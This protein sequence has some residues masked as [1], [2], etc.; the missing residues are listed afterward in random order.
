[1]AYSNLGDSEHDDDSNVAVNSSH[2]PFS[3]EDDRKEVFF[4][5]LGIIRLNL[6]IF[7]ILA[8]II[9][10]LVLTNRKL[11]SPTSM[12]LLSLVVYDAVYLLLVIPLSA[13]GVYVNFHASRDTM[14][15]MWTITRVTYPLR[16]MAQMGS[17][18]TT[19]TITIERCLIILLPL[20]AKSM[21]TRGVTRRA[22]SG[23]LIFSVLFNVP[24]C[25]DHILSPGAGSLSSSFKSNSSVP[26][27][28]ESVHVPSVNVKLSSTKFKSPLGAD[29][30]NYDPKK[31]FSI[32]NR[33]VA[34]GH[35]R[36]S[37]C[38][39]LDYQNAALSLINGDD[40]EGARDSLPVVGSLLDDDSSKWET[41]ERGKIQRS[42]DSTRSESGIYFLYHEVYISYLT[43]FFLY[44]IPY[45]L[46]IL[47]NARLLI[48]LR[49]RREETRRVSVRQEH[50]IR[51]LPGPAPTDREDG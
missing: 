19:V 6:A 26:A 3:L 4:I 1:M 50:R 45:T 28:V 49:R 22:I 13:S 37:N 48:A 21:W 16:Y 18:Y 33:T 15:V 39:S 43:T 12:L 25:F 44:L 10:A 42:N 47:F 17:T 30:I 14:M 20:R 23:V 7:G 34:T 35:V 38:Q 32:E 40:E 2:V 24:R 8:N 51:S 36:D 9:S 27:G 5:A 41:T 31:C 46:I 29:N 11:W